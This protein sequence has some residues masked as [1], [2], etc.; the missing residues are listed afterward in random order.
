M[1]SRGV[2]RD[3]RGLEA[4]PTGCLPHPHSACFEDVAEVA[5]ILI[6]SDLHFGEELLPGASVERREAVEVGSDAFREFVR[7]Y[8]ARR[9]DG[10]PWRLVIAGDLFDFM[11]VVIPGTREQPARTA[12]ERR[13][14][15][16]RGRDAGVT[17]M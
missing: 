6:V 16:G 3:P 15:L 13:F 17:R 7:Y 4:H 12:D 5:N 10:R 14:G 1:A 8:T 2:A 9:V 11:S